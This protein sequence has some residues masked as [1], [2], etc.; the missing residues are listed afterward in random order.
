M[1]PSW[2][3][4]LTMSG[5]PQ[6]ST[7]RPSCIRKKS[8]PFV[9]VCFSVAGM[10]T[11]SPRWCRCRSP[12]GHQLALGDHVLDL[13]VQIREGLVDHAEELLGLLGALAA[14]GVVDP[15]T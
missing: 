13:S 4:K 14:E 6:C 5:P 10:P 3:R 12:G 2:I 15:I 7:C 1:T 11:N 9:L 8:T